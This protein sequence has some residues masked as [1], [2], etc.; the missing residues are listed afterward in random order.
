MSAADATGAYEWPAGARFA[1]ELATLADCRGRAVCD[2]G[3][4]RGALG[5]I[6]LVSG[7]RSVAFLD[8]AA[9][10]VATLRAELGGDPRASFHLHRWG[11]AAPG[12]PYDLI[13]G[14]DILYRPDCFA[15]LLDSIAG[16]LAHDGLCLLSDPRTALEPELPSLARERGLSWIASRRSDV[17][18]VQLRAAASLAR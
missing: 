3:C 8:G 13:L 17:T 15:A 16:G 12:A 9:D 11:E 18:V 1:R 6:A 10:V 4:G 7:A 2:L 5:R 14:G